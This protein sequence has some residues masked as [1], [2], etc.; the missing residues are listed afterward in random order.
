MTIGRVL[1]LAFVVIASGALAGCG[2][3][4]VPASPS[5][6][7]VDGNWNLAGNRALGQYPLLSV[8][9]VVNGSQI[10]A[11]GDMQVTCANPPA[12]SVGGNFDLTGQIASDGTFQ[13][14]APSNLPA[15]SLKIVVN[16]TLPAKGA[17]NWTGEYSI[18]D[19]P[20][21]TSCIVNQSAPFTAAE[22]APF[23]GTYAGT[24]TTQ[25]GHATASLTVS[26]GAATAFQLPSGPQYYLPLEATLAVSGSPC[27]TQGA[28]TPAPINSIEGDFSNMNFAMNDGSQVLVSGWFTGPNESAFDAV[29]FAVIGGKCDQTTYYGTLNHQ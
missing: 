22:F 15:G 7:S 20:G 1:S 16:G 26:Q 2:G 21:Y 17:T 9:I 5:F 23:D 11:N 10:T 25:S 14:A 8:A 4:I 6:G 27:F 3:L 24:L 19:S 18:T 28:T 12:D 29:V 13:L